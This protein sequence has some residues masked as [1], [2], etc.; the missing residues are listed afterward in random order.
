MDLL[1]WMH[2]HGS[3][4]LLLVLPDGTKSLIPAEWTDLESAPAPED[5]KPTA[6]DPFGIFCMSGRSSTL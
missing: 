5:L 2:R 4:E 1:G 6:S 3:L